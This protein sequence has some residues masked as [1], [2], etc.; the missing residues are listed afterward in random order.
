MIID[1]MTSNNFEFVCSHY[2]MRTH[3][4]C[5]L[6]GHGGVNAIFS[7]FVIGSGDNAPFGWIS[8]TADDNGFS[9]ELRSP[10]LLNS[11][12][13]GVHVDMKNS[14]HRVASE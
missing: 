4:I 3:R 12:E 6:H 9:F 10:F 2:R 1:H 13:E 8:L 7:G 14:S 5:G 11:G